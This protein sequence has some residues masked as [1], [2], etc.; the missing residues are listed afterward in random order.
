MT[1]NTHRA[2]LEFVQRHNFVIILTVANF[3][4]RW[5]QLCG[6]YTIISLIKSNSLFI[7]VLIST[8]KRL[9]K[10]HREYSIY[11]EKENTHRNEKNT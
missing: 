10:I 8:T 7:Y 1:R 2:G 9:L 4:V 11:N 6:K 5:R 3:K